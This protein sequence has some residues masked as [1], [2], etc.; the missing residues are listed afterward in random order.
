MYELT[1]KLFIQ[2]IVSAVALLTVIVSASMV[3]AWSGP[4]AVAPSGNVAAP[5]NVGTDDQVKNGGLSLT[6]LAV[7]G[8]SALNGSVWAN[9]DVSIINN[10]KLSVSGISEYTG[11]QWV[12]ANVRIIGP[13]HTLVLQNGTEA[14]GKVLTSDANG[15]ATWQ[16]PSASSGSSSSGAHT[17]VFSPNFAG[18]S[19]H[20]T[21]QE[22]GNG[23]VYSGPF[24]GAPYNF[25]ADYTTRTRIC[26][27]V[28]AAVSGFNAPSVSEA[29]NQSGSYS[30]PDDNKVIF[31]NEGGGYYELGPADNYYNGAKNRHIQKMSCSN[32]SITYY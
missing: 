9:G 17:A 28:N 16:T 30:S 29:V 12:N 26:H 14:V 2:V 4:T 15:V 13:G 1:K 3:V 21:L 6:S 22:W 31:W 24:S 20:L 25:N 7:W 27:D 10:H 11:D 19:T 5:V 8:G 23:I 18:N 32:E